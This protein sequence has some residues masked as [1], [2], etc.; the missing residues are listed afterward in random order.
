M[1][2]SLV[3]IQGG[4]VPADTEIVRS[5]IAWSGNTDPD[6]SVTIRLEKFSSV[7]ASNTDMVYTQTFKSPTSPLLI[8]NYPRGIFFETGSIPQITSNTINTYSVQHVMKVI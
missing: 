7:L 5:A 2:D 8:I 1:S 4:F 3:F 6:G